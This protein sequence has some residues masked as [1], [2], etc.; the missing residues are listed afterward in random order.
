MLS[1]RDIM[2]VASHGQH[3]RATEHVKKLG[4][5]IAQNFPLVKFGPQNC[6]SSRYG[7]FVAPKFS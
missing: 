6:L 4:N 1:T 5:Q 2:T 3:T 7:N